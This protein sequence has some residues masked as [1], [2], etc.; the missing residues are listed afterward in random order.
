MFLFTLKQVSDIENELGFKHEI[1]L[2]RSPVKY[3]R[4]LKAPLLEFPL[5]VWLLDCLVDSLHQ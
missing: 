1:E 5:L 3:L 4:T 2:R